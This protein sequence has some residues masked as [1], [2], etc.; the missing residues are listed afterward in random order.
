M[1]EKTAIIG[2]AHK[3]RM[4][5]WFFVAFIMLCVLGVPALI[6]LEIEP[7]KD[8][9]W[10]TL[11]Y[12]LFDH[13]M[14]PQDQI[15]SDTLTLGVGQA[16]MFFMMFLALTVAFAVLVWNIDRLFRQYAQGDI[17]TAQS[18]CR[19]FAIGWSLIALFLLNT[20][21][22]N[23]IEHYLRQEDVMFLEEVDGYQNMIAGD[24]GGLFT[25]FI[26]LDFSLLLAG[27]FV[28]AVARVMQL[29]VQLQDDV[30]ATV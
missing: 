28:V 16:T 5:L 2:T 20:L 15:F 19:F 24:M 11:A 12:M 18:I 22:D 4:F 17:F 30:N 23:L 27:V 3:A 14:M 8:N 9:V 7:L 6:N 29:G 21:G 25:Y 1:K 10:I 26:S 13:A